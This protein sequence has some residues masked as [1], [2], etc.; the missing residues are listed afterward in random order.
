MTWWIN[1][2]GRRRK[3]KTNWAFETKRKG[4]Q[5]KSRTIQTQIRE[6][7]QRI[8]WMNGRKETRFRRKD[9]KRN[10]KNW[11]SLKELRFK[12]WSI[13]ERIYK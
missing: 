7:S 9:E 5:I 10:G 2:K 1:E 3:R 8:Y 12:S 6:S 11:K 4:T 13:K